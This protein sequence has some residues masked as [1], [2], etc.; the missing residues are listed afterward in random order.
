MKA[1]VIARREF[2]GTRNLWI[3]AAFM[4]LFAM[5]SPWTLGHQG[6]KAIDVRIALTIAGGLGFA[7]VVGLLLG[8][9][10]FG[11]DLSQRRAGFFLS[12]PVGGASLY[13]GKLTGVWLVVTLGAWLVFAPL[14]AIQAGVATEAG[15]LLAAAALIGLLS[16]LFGHTGSIILRARSPWLILDLATAGGFTLL[17]W[18]NLWSLLKAGAVPAAGWMGAFLSGWV[19]AGLLLAGLLQVD[20]GRA[21]LRGSHRVLS[22]ALACT[23]LPGGI[24][25]WLVGWSLRHPTPSRLRSAQV[26]AVQPGGPWVLISGDLRGYQYSFRHMLLN[27]ATGR[28]FDLGYWGGV[29]S[30]DGRRFLWEGG[31]VSSS[32]GRFFEVQVADLT[33]DRPTFRGSTAA[34]PSG[35]NLIAVSGDGSRFLTRQWDTQSSPHRLALRVYDSSSGRRLAMYRAPHSGQCRAVEFLDANRVRAYLQVTSGQPT[36]TVLEALEWDFNSGPPR[37]LWQQRFEGDASVRIHEP[38]SGDPL[39]LSVRTVGKG[40]ALWLCPRGTGAPRRLLA[41]SKVAESLSGCFLGDGDLLTLQ[42][43][44]SVYELRRLDTT[45]DLKGRWEFSPPAGASK[46]IVPSLLILGEAAPG[47]VILQWEAR[48]FQPGPPLQGLELDLGTG[49]SRPFADGVRLIPTV[50][51]QEPRA[52]PGGLWSR[53][54]RA[55]DGSLQIRRSDGSLKRLTVAD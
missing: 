41:E 47:R 45:A 37:L 54:H 18:S 7:L 23:L 27:T 14:L 8:A 55:A 22:L 40:R 38:P 52:E 34:L 32:Q 44:G 26:Y 36:A 42:Q 33:M 51:K 13:F 28:H 9:G 31:G 16:I 53:L 17:V 5:A 1:L 11:S 46:D 4:G 19:L 43:R 10:M 12:R 20:K 3:G 50:W 39:L 30:G 21:D 24:G 29:F 6:Q 49:T 2:L 25:A 15:G 48:G 35:E